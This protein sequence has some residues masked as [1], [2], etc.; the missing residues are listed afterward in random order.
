MVLGV[1]ESKYL[2]NWSRLG[3]DFCDPHVRPGGTGL[4]TSK[5]IWQDFGDVFAQ[6]AEGYNFDD[7]QSPTRGVFSADDLAAAAAEYR[8]C[9]EPANCRHRNGLPPPNMNRNDSK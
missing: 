9:C 8:T 6:L 3:I 2:R 7:I 5:T 1:R 4:C